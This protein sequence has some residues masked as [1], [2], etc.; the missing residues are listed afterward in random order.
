VSNLLLEQLTAIDPYPAD[1]EVPTSAVSSTA[2]LIELERKA[3]VAT[4][5]GTVVRSI[6]PVW[7]GPLVAAAVFGVVLVVAIVL[8][9]TSGG[10]EPAAPVTTT[11][12]EPP[13][14]TVPPAP[15]TTT[16]LPP[17]T[18]TT[19]PDIVSDIEKSAADGV[20]DALNAADIDALYATMT[21]SATLRVR[22]ERLPTP[23][24]TSSREAFERYIGVD[25]AIGAQW[26]ITNCSPASTRSSIRCELENAEPLREAFGLDILPALLLIDVD[27]SGA[28]EAFDLR[29]DDAKSIIEG[30]WLND[31]APFTD[32]LKEAYPDDFRIMTINEEQIRTSPESLELWRVHVPEF[33]ATLDQ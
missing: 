4:T 18:T 16:T 33:L 3:G 26:T 6:R 14:T 22:V 9:L 28:I 11:V 23:A 17:A 25:F 31:L 10:A 7:R 27:D 20:V 32:W 21:E 29:W 30:T 12:T 19:V 1:A 15:T 13:V 8:S 2:A 5:A 24:I